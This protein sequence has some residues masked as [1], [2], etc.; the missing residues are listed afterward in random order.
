MRSH[1]TYALAI[2][3]VLGASAFATVPSMAQPAGDVR[4]NQCV[5]TRDIARNAVSANRIRNNAV[6]T[7]KI[8]PNAVTEGKILD[9][10]V[11]PSKLSDTAKP[12]GVEHEVTSD[13]NVS[14]TAA[15]IITVTLDAPAD[16]FAVVSSSWYFAMTLANLNATCRLIVQGGSNLG[17][18]RFAQSNNVVGHRD[19]AAITRL[20]P[21][22]AGPNTFALRCSG[23]GAAGQNQ[24]RQPVITA[25]YVPQR[26]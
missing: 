11:S 12:A 17:H 10:A 14:A 9:G 5:G 26:Y 13:R 15:D 6:G 20:F 18:F 7:N 22:T 4:C 16:G 24:I 2:A 21:V 3:V 8:A 25:I 23:N 19:N 1:N